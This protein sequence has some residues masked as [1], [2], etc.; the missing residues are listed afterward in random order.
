MLLGL[1]YSNLN[2]V[3]ILQIHDTKKASLHSEL[4]SSKL[5]ASQVEDVV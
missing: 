1:K 5:T 4:T 2:E 3:T